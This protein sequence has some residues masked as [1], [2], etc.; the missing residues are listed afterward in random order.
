M[1]IVKDFNEITSYLRKKWEEEKSISFIV[2]G[3]N[4]LYHNKRNQFNFKRFEVLVKDLEIFTSRIFIILPEYFRF[5]Y[6]ESKVLQNLKSSGKIFYTP[7]NWKD[8]Y[9]ILDFAKKFEAFVISNDRYKEFHKDYPILT[10]KKILP[11][12]IIELDEEIHIS[13]PSLFFLFSQFQ[14]SIMEEFCLWKF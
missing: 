1:S 14:Y 9:F 4:F 10:Q 6:K 2:D 12:T 7:S 11:F 3:A 5:R 13:I 8:D